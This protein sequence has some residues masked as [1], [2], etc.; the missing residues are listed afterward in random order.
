[1]I[2]KYITSLQ[3]KIR[4]DRRFFTFGQLFSDFDNLRN[5]M[6]CTSIQLNRAGFPDIIAR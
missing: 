5:S 3:G 4:L 1:M 2:F 6:G